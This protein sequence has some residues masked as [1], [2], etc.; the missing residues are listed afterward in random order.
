M[1]TV[2]ADARPALGEH[3]AHIVV[4]RG[5]ESLPRAEAAGRAFRAV[6]P[7]D[8]ARTDLA[9]PGDHGGHR[10]RL[11]A[12]NGLVNIA[13]FGKRRPVHRLDED[14]EDTSAGQAHREGVIVTEAVPLKYGL[15]TLGDLRG[16]LVD[17]TLDAAAGNGADHVAAVL[18]GERGSRI[19]RRAAERAHNRRKAERLVVG[20]PLGDGVQNVTHCSYLEVSL[21]LRYRA[22]A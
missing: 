7:D 2:A 20:P 13:E 14:V 17:R 16:E 12:L 15:T 11:A 21:V 5:V 22:K 9:G 10:D 18:H 19:A 8:P 1:L 4:H 6:A 3:A